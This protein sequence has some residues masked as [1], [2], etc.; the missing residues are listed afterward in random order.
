MGAVTHGWNCV[1]YCLLDTHVHLVV[2]TPKPNLGR[3]MRLLLGRYAITYNRRRP[4][5]MDPMFHL[6]T[7]HY[8]RLGL[9]GPARAAA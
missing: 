8:G 6:G 9:K 7:T 2:V 1:A 4:A 3:G 5:V